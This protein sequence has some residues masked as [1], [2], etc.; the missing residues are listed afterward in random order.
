MKNLLKSICII[1]SAIAA[2]SLIKEWS[3]FTFKSFLVPIIQ[4]YDWFVLNLAFYSIDVFNFEW[5]VLDDSEKKIISILTLF[6]LSPFFTAHYE[7]MVS[8]QEKLKIELDSQ[9]AVNVITKFL[10]LFI[11]FTLVGLA[12]GYL[13]NF[14]TIPGAFAVF[15]YLYFGYLEKTVKEIQTRVMFNLIATIVSAIGLAY[16]DSKF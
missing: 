7:Y 3:D 12:G 11:T 13:P 10:C 8:N 6:C 4:G 2:L 15:M 5:Y 16:V 9:T 14:L 1:F